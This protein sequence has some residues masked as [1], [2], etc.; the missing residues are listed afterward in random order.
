MPNPSTKSRFQ[1]RV[2]STDQERCCF[3]GANCRASACLQ[4]YLG[5][6]QVQAAVQ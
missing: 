6:R 4:P 1:V 5:K 2:K 3:L